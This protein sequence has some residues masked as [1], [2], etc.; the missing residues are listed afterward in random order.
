MIV[1]NITIVNYGVLNFQMAT[2]VAINS[3]GAVQGVGQQASAAVQVTSL[4][5][6]SAALGHGRGP[7]MP[8]R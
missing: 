6:G 8:L 3:P 5:P 1:Y 7:M 4:G 2:N